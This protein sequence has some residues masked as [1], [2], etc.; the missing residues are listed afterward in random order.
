M[1]D[2]RDPAVAESWHASQLAHRARGRQLDLLID[3]LV[4]LAPARVVDVGVGSGLVAERILERLPTVSLV[5]IDFSTVMLAE[6]RTRLSSWKDR[7]DLVEGNVS[8]PE[9][10]GALDDRAFDVAITVQTLHKIDHEGQQR[11]LAWTHG[12][13]APGAVLLSLDKV[14]ITRPLYD[15][16]MRLGPSSTLGDFPESFDDYEKRETSAGEHSPPL[17]AY[18]DWLRQAGF[19]AGV[20]DVEANYALVAARA[21]A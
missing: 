7:V 10:I 18:L 16:Y 13:L 8:H 3:L 15:L 1:G 17:E 21:R 4:V 14:S 20:L 2:F 9:S 12:L 19:E 11:A 6:A 5:G